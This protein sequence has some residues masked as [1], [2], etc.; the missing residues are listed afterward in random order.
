MPVKYTEEMLREAVS[1]SESYAEV[2]RTLGTGKSGSTLGHIKNRIQYF[3]IDVTHFTHR[4]S[5]SEARKR[6]TIEEILVI[7]SPES[8]RESRQNLLRALHA[9]NIPYF[10]SECQLGEEWNNKIINLEIDHINGNSRD[11]RLDNLRF[12]CPNCHSQEKTSNKSKAYNLYS[13]NSTTIE[14]ALLHKNLQKNKNY[15]KCPSCEEKMYITS[16]LCKKCVVK[17]NN[18]NS[19]KNILRGYDIREVI[20]IVTKTNYTQAA[21]IIGCSDNAIRKFFTRNNIDP[22][23]LA[24]L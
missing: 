17:E 11:N 21:K 7:S 8:R 18:F 6:K 3:N 23:T 16:N 4:N 13:M 22:K 2:A 20:D 5:S 9:K 15:T 14:K 24:I 12:L 1:K 19:S 10:C